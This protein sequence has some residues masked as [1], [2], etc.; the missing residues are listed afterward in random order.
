MWL[1]GCSLPSPKGSP[2]VCTGCGAG[3]VPSLW[4]SGSGGHMQLG[5]WP[6]CQ[7]WYFAHPCLELLH[8]NDQVLVL[9]LH[10]TLLLL[11]LE[12]LFVV[13]APAEVQVQLQCLYRG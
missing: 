13:C 2:G 5:L 11:Q 4:W 9:L 3:M 7:R 12:Q 8:Q 1:A 10:C 6:L